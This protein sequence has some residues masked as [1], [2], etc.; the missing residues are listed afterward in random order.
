[1]IPR[2]DKPNVIVCLC[3]QLRAFDV[4]CYGSSFVRTPNM[5]AFA[6]QGVRFETACSNNPL[7]TPARSILLSGQYSRTCAG[8]LTNVG[9]PEPERGIFPDPT[10]ADAFKAAGYRTGLI[11]KWHIGPHPR[12][13]GF[14]SAFFPHH[15]HRYTGQ[16]YF[17]NDDRSR[18]IDGFAHEAELDELSR[19][20]ETDPGEPFFLYYNISQPHMPLAD[21]PER[22]KQMYAP[23]DV[24]LRANVFADGKAACDENWFLIYLWDYLYYDRHLP[25]TVKL[26]EG[27]DLRRLTALYDGSVTWADDQLG[28]L[29][30]KLAS[31]GLDENTIVLFTSDHG[32]N[33]GSHQLFNKDRLYEESIRIPMMYRWPGGLATPPSPPYQGGDG[34][35][36]DT[37][38][39]S[40]VDVM[41]TLL[42][43]AGVDVPKSVQG[44]DVS[45][46]LS[47][48]NASV[49]ENAAF[50]ETSDGPVGIRTLEHLYGINKAKD[51]KHRTSDVTDDSYMFFDITRDPLQA[52]N[53]AD[54]PDAVADDLRERVLRWDRETPWLRLEG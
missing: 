3:D 39:A 19:F 17:D 41:P 8:S 32:D 53:L 27:F 1:M 34:G 42:S 37:Q 40:L 2:R 48:E 54:Q 44:V 20:L 22:Y 30:R 11:G 36:I 49:G 25:Y 14:D 51:G 23:A 31:A 26:P 18:V 35:V 43:L 4:G 13:L 6:S 52:R 46:V 5:D 21:I 7:C 16:T 10:I 12:T 45:R 15:S 33:L 24:P 28:E 50:I 38:V 47:G 9:E 29:M